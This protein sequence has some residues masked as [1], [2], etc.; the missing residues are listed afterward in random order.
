MIVYGFRH[1][2]IMSY[3]LDAVNVDFDTAHSLNLLFTHQNHECSYVSVEFNRYRGY[4][5]RHKM[6][7]CGDK[8]SNRCCDGY[9]RRCDRVTDCGN[10]GQVS[11]YDRLRQSAPMLTSNL[12]ELSWRVPQNM[13]L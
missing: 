5:T 11:R 9:D 6:A 8:G 13:S 1:A 2:C 10:G 7:E 3:I 12:K 4:L